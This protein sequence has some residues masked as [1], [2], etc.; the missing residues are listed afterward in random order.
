MA[1]NARRRP[2]V[3]DGAS[4]IDHAAKL[5][6]PLN[7]RNHAGL[8]IVAVR[9]EII[10]SGQCAAEAYTGRG[11]SPVLALCRKLI[12]AGY[13]PAT[14]LEA[15]RGAVM[16]LRARSIGEA[17]GLQVNGKGTAFIKRRVPV[18]TASPV[19]L[20][21]EAAAPLAAEAVS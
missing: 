18:G 14:P 5:I 21:R 12:A 3:T 13:D 15:F 9:A 1:A 20:Q 17:A 6:N 11:A 19:R 8:Q 10:N 16:C 2:L 7:N 4:G